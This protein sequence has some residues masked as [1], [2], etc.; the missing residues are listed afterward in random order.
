MILSIISDTTKNEYKG[1][2]NEIPVSPGDVF[3]IP[4][5]TV[6]A[7]CGE[8]LVGE[9]QQSSDIT[10]RIYD[11]DRVGLDGKPRQ[12]HIEEALEVINFKQVG[13]QKSNGLSYI[14]QGH[15]ITI[16][17]ACK[18]FSVEE[19]KLAGTLNLQKDNLKFI[20]LTF[21]SGEAV[22]KY[23]KNDRLDVKAGDTIF[24]PAALRDIKIMGRGK[25]LKSYVPDIKN[26]IIQKLIRYGYS[27]KDI[28]K[29]L[30]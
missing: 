6:H 2:F 28:S 11:W 10:Y 7:I 18:Y 29:C 21:I 1:I 15:D 26:D 19:I 14:E 4:P 12:L 13:L 30:A 25:F 23:G 3:F 8:V 27:S 20:I 24:I 9:I 16:W 22:V 17:G 5:G